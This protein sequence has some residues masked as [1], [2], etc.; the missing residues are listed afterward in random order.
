MKFI[1]KC[2]QKDILDFQEYNKGII[3][4]Q[5][6]IQEELLKLIQEAVNEISLD[7]YEVK[8]YGS[9]ATNLCLPWSDLDLV[10]VNKKNSSTYSFET[11]RAI[12][13][14]LKVKIRK[15]HLN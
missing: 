12:F 14:I 7:T 13:V 15:Y 11:L 6:P 10:L 4:K 2:L 8:I 3:R 9:H 1:S 5:K